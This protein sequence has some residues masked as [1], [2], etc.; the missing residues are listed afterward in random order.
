M[1][2]EVL[3]HKFELMRLHK[4]TGRDP[5]ERQLIMYNKNLDAPEVLQNHA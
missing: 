3:L 4:T 1:T 5:G 2:V